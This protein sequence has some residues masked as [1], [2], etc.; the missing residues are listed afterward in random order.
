MKF[1][2]AYHEKVFLNP[3]GLHPFSE[4][5]HLM[6]LQTLHLLAQFR[7]FTASAVAL[8]VEKF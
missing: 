3:V 7:G 5:A 1:P 2:I 8:L 4:L 6:S